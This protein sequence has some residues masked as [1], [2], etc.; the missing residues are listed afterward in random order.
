MKNLQQLDKQYLWHP[1]APMRL[2]LDGEPLII[3]RG[4]GVYL[5]DTDGNRYIDGVASLWCNV[6]G[7]CHGHI[8]SAISSQ[9]EKIAHSTLLG[10]SS[11]P[12]IR[13]A[14]RLVEMTPGELARVFYSDSG[15]TAVEIALKMAFQY[16]KNTGQPNRDKFIALKQ[17]YHGDTVGAV[18]V[19]GIE[20]FHRIFG[21]LTF[22]THFTDSPHPYR[23]DGSAEQC[24]QSALARLEQLLI[25][26][27][28]AIAAIV[29]EP[30]V[31]GA[32]GI[33]V[34]P[35][36]FLAGAA[37]LAEKF[38]VLLIADEVATGFGRTGTMFACSQE[39]VSPD[40]LCLA[41]GL[42]GGYLPLAATLTTEKVFAAFL[43]EPFAETTFYHGHTYSGNA[44]ACAA[45]VAS[46]EVFE[47]EG[48]VESLPPK[49][50]LIEERLRQI[51]R[52]DFVGDVRQ[53]GLMVGIE[54]TK[55]KDAKCDFPPEA[56]LGA[57][58][59]DQ[60]RGDGLILRPLG[61]VIVIMPPLSI[62]L[63]QLGQL[64]DIVERAIADELPLLVESL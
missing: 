19:G 11:A 39:N 51:G 58:I 33:V 20:T 6:H 30:L 43:G 36:G 12:A 5:Y 34:H 38:D 7:H 10:L 54:L 45:A 21:P 47:R 44:L 8:N 29:L 31:Q 59:C 4:D 22:A 14:G 24:R 46:L 27:A 48:T 56:R 63:A 2:W 25:E 32:A 53:K 18:S 64:L 13:L 28:G 16:W 17:S 23:F 15:A 37:A 62:D 49:I 41:K 3:D 55:D 1:F 26:N 52:L 9:L 60:M 42:T 35:E 61:D 40:I 57:R 50:S